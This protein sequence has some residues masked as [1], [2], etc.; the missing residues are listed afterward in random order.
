MG[1]RLG[2]A[3]TL[4]AIGK[5]CFKEGNYLKALHFYQQRIKINQEIGNQYIEAWIHIYIGQIRVKLDQKWETQSLDSE[6]SG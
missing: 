3:S 5:L 4:K 1:A 2:E 6:R